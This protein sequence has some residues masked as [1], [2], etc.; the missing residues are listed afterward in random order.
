MRALLNAPGAYDDW[1]GVAD[2]LNFLVG[3]MDDYSVT[4]YQ[5]LGEQAFGA[6]L[7]LAALSDPAKLADFLA[8]VNQLPG[9]RITDRCGRHPA[10]ESTLIRAAS[11]CSVSVSRWTAT[12]C[13][14]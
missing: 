12:S 7:P 10:D 3:P 4:E 9:P 11:G 14:S 6:G 5:P 2:T 8:G 1:S 13:S